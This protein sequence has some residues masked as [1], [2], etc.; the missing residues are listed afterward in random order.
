MAPNLEEKPSV[1]SEDEWEF[2]QVHETENGKPRPPLQMKWRNV[3]IFTFLHLSAAY[4][5]YL[6]ITVARPST[7]VWAYVLHFLGAV[8]ITAG[9]HRLWSHRSYK[10]KTSLRIILMLMDTLAFETDILDW[11]RDHRVH[12]RFS[13]T[14]ADPHNARRGFFYAHIGWLFCKK[15]PD[16]IEK[17]RQ[18]DLSDLWADPVVK[19][20]R[21]HYFKLVFLCWFLLPTYI[22]HFLWGETVKTAFFV[23][24]LRYCW[25]L[26]VTW[27]VNSAAHLWGTTPYD[28]TINPRDSYFVSIVASGEGWHNYHHTFPMD[29]KTAELPYFFNAPTAFISFF[30]RLGL[31][32]DLK[33]VPKD[34]IDKRRM[35]TGDLSG[36]HRH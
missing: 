21:R 20:Q 5:M 8:G 22:P 14:D 29:Y 13:E 36:H 1:L 2:E 27:L 28:K 16:V 19:F 25:T 4:G 30:A 11:C 24:M 33:S 34:V 7:L 17:G 10:A 3:F 31:A 15:H 23:N 35:R 6:T 32:Y 18:V 12:H 9:A 26:N